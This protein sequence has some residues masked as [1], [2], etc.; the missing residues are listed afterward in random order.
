M[1][2]SDVLETFRVVDDEQAEAGSEGSEKRVCL[3]KPDV[4]NITVLT[5]SL[6]NEPILPW[7]HFD[8]PWLEKESATTEESQTE[9]ET[10]EHAGDDGV[11]QL[12]LELEQIEPSA[13]LSED[14]QDF[15]TDSL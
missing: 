14:S 2:F 9:S 15:D 8:S 11:Q 4:N 1:A 3:P 6:P 13:E 10:S 12:T 7:H 5:E